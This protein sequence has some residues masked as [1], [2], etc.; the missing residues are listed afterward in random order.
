MLHFALSHSRMDV[1]QL[2]LDTGVVEVDKANKVGN[3]P[4]LISALAVE[5]TK[6]NLEVLQK[7][8]TIGNVNVTAYGVSRPRVNH[9]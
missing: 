3:T 4:I 7:L 9:G 5:P 6:F 2:V 1:V 8:F